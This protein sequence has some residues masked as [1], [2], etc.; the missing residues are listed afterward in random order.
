MD[1]LVYLVEGLFLFLFL[2]TLWT[3]YK[4]RDLVSR[5]LALVFSALAV[6]F[7]AEA[8]ELITGVPAG[9]LSAIGALLLILQPVFAL[10][11]V[12]L[13]RPV[14]RRLLFGGTIALLAPVVPALLLRGTPGASGLMTVATFVLIAAFVVLE[15]IAAVYLLLE[16]IRREGP[17]SARMGLAAVST[18]VFAAALFASIVGNA[19]SAPPEVSRATAAGLALLAGI[20][21]VFAFLTPAPIRRTWQAATTVEYTQSLIAR[22]GEPVPAIWATFAETATHMQGGSAVVI[23]GRR[24]GSYAIVASAGEEIPTDAIPV[25]QDELESLVATH[26]LGWDVPVEKVVPLGQ[27]LAELA[28]ARFVSIVPIDV[29]ESDAVAVLV[30]LSSHR[31]LFHPS[32]AELLAALGAQ[33]AIVAE[34]R[35]VMAEQEA[36][37]DRLATTVEAL[38]SASAA[39]SDF[40]ASMSHEFRTPLSAIIGFSDLM[41]TEPRDGDKVT[42]PIEWVDHIQ[43]GGQH[44]LTLVNDVLDLARVEAGRLELRPEPV[45]VGHAVSEAVNGLRPLADR[46]NLQFQADARSFGVV[47]D[48]GRF[49]QI[50]YNLIS[51]AIKYTPDGGSIKVTASRVGDEVRIAVA[52]TG[53]GISPEDQARVFEEFRQVGDPSERQPGSGLG[54]AVTKRLAEAHDGRIELESARGQGSTFTLVLPAGDRDPATDETPQAPATIDDAST[55]SGE[56]LVIEDDPSAVRLLREYLEAAGYRVR[57]SATGETGLASARSERPAAIVLD[58]LLPGMDGWEVLRKLKADAELQDVPVVIVTVVEERE[59]GLAL[60]AVDYLVKPIHREALLGCLARFVAADDSKG[61]AKRV[62]VVDDELAS[63]AYIRGAL[64]PEGVV[65]VTAQGG[66]EALEWAETGQL[67]DLVVC[68]LVMPDVDGFEVIAALKQNERTADLPIVVCT[69]HD[70]S[71]EQKAKLNGKI[72][73]IVAKGQ[74]A[75][76]GLL[77]WLDHALPAAS[78]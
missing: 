60:G 52:D 12:S 24:A 17:V 56:I 25:A 77:D 1:W 57:I 44:L 3:W 38:R 11:L 64:E 45:D 46:K 14:P 63:L 34:R 55:M 2:A 65:V 5:D 35:A 67:V 28:H 59:I 54:L 68:D 58:V 69:A 74:D 50:L 42:V 15:A 75:R 76:V 73:G 32:D 13:I 70:L 26:R 18:G 71:A 6:L 37:T 4:Q 20:G 33:T 48:R 72:L 39:K 78:R 8:W 41:T 51:N 62:L 27:R 21:Y 30:L 61:V 40:V 31:A 16:A 43:R 49:R 47:V 23:T 29:P 36:L 9:L 66:R 22:S 53:V 10:H 19:A 7:V